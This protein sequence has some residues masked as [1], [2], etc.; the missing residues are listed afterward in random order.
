VIE[1]ELIYKILIDDKLYRAEYWGRG[2]LFSR[3]WIIDTPKYQWFFSATRIE[4]Q[5]KVIDKFP[6]ARFFKVK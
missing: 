3:G 1:P 2:G 5:R 6:G 4:M